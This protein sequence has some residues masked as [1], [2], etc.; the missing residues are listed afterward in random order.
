LSVSRT[1]PAKDSSDILKMNNLMI[2]ILMPQKFVK[3]KIL[4]IIN[5]MFQKFLILAILPLVENIFLELLVNCQ[6]LLFE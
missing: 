1:N 6:H 2:I 5:N 4:K 3:R